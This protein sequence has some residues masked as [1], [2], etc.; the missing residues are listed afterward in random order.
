MQLRAKV[1]G[2]LEGILLHG[3]SPSGVDLLAKYVDLTGD[4]QTAS[5]AMGY[6]HGKRFFDRRV[7]TWIES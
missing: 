7:T 6:V 5:L 2:N 4:V 3:F 1:N